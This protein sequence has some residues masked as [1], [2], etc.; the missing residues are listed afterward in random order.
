[1]GVWPVWDISIRICDCLSNVLYH[2]PG[3]VVVS[4]IGR[5]VCLLRYGFGPVFLLSNRVDD[6]MENIVPMFRMSAYDIFLILLA[7]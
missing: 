2:Q 7:K 4:L 3:E 1:M 5:L 6:L